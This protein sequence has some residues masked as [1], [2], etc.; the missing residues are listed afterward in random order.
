M[1]SNSHKN[2]KLI[3]EHKIKC[4]MQAN[5]SGPLVHATWFKNSNVSLHAD[6]D[7]Y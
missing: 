3:K 7:M 1:E 2:A 6:H 4:K 5:N